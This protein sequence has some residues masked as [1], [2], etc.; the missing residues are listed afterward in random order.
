MENLPT[1]HFITSLQFTPKTYQDVY[2]A[3][4]P[5][6]NSLAGKVAIITGA[7]RGIG[8]E[9]RPTPPILPYSLS[10]PPSLSLPRPASPADIHTR[11]PSTRA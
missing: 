6:N 2:P 7:S 5:K 3:I 10:L 8:G 1:D 9:V 4:D 11:P